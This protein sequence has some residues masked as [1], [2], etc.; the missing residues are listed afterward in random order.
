MLKQRREL[1]TEYEEKRNQAA[2][3]WSYYER[4]AKSFGPQGL[5]ARIIQAAQ[6]LI[7]HNANETLRRL[8]HGTWEIELR[9]DDTSS[10]LE[11]LARDLSQSGGASTCV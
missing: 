2:R 3:E 10:E 9:E 1:H 8:S 7:R 11:I 4:L 6:D 5:Q